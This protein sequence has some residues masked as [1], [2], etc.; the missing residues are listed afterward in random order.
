M[1][2]SIAKE[3]PHIEMW[4]Y[5]KSLKYWIKRI[6]EIPYNLIL[7]ASYGGKDDALINEYDLKNVVVY[8]SINDVPINRPIDNNDDYARTPKINF[9]LLDNI[10]NNKKNTDVQLHNTNYKR[11]FI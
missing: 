3:N 4:A 5:T 9:A 1:W 8:K 7:T 10:K 2:L 11:N 6:N